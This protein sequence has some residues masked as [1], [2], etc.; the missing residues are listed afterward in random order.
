MFLTQINNKEDS[1]NLH[2]I[3]TKMVLMSE[4]T[5]YN[6]IY[7]YFVFRD[8]NPR[9]KTGAVTARPAAYVLP[10]PY[11]RPYPPSSRRRRPPSRPST[12]FPLRRKQRMGRRRT[13]LRRRAKGEGV[14]TRIVPQHL[15]P[16]FQV[17]FLV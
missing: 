2:N 9:A 6:L 8:V 3:L 5:V 13:R 16:L 12:S 14:P 10:A 1:S 15:R 4:S 17:F 11:R 7:N